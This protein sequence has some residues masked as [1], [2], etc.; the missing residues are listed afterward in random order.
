MTDTDNTPTPTDNTALG[1]VERV[2]P[3]TT[4]LTS[5]VAEDSRTPARGPAFWVIV[6]Q[7]SLGRNFVRLVLHTGHLA[8]AILVPF[9]LT[10][11]APV[12]SRRSL[13]LTQ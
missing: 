11:I 3:T 13:H 9:A 4:L 2:P 6:G 5:R 8:L 10:S 12:A 7:A 1:A